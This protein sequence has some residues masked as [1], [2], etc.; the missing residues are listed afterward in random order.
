[1]TNHVTCC[2]CSECLNGAPRPTRFD[3]SGQWAARGHTRLSKTA[4]D[5]KAAHARRWVRSWGQ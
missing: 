2:D 1:M 5:R 3:A 4:R